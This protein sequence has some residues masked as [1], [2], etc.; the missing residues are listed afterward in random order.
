MGC[1]LF[2]HDRHTS[3]HPFLLL[4]PQLLSSEMFSFFFYFAS[5][6]TLSG[7]E[8]HGALTSAMTH[9]VS[10]CRFSGPVLSSAGVV[11]ALCLQQP[12]PP[13]SASLWT[14]PRLRALG[15]WLHL[16][17]PPLGWS[18]TPLWTALR[19]GTWQ[20]PSVS[21]LASELGRGKTCE[22]RA[23][24]PTG[25]EGP[26]VHRGR[27]LS[28]GLRSEVRGCKRQVVDILSLVDQLHAGH[29]SQYI[30]GRT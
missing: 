4:D 21:T 5:L 17:R 12:L 8:S 14:P 24:R 11:A 23:C 28:V 18:T 1:S 2:R 13:P 25:S 3:A 15:A 29:Q 27:G 6:Q 10:T 30:H 22:G 16:A 20:R 7:G 26:A 19:P 9:N